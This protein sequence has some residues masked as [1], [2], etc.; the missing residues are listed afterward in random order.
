M[1]KIMN[2]ELFSTTLQ[3]A[4]YYIQSCRRA[5]LAR[6]MH[7]SCINQETSLLLKS[8]LQGTSDYFTIIIDK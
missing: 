8:A 7:R 5:S 2:C 1:D 4:Q 3:Y 6:S